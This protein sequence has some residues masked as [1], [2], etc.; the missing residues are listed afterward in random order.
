M[1]YF[2]VKPDGTKVPIV[3]LEKD[4]R[5]IKI[6]NLEGDTRWI[7]FTDFSLNENLIL[8]K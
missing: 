2:L 7:K 4:D 3:V 5:S 1:I 6:S 8:I